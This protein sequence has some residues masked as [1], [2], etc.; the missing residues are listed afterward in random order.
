M[1]IAL[2][3]AALVSLAAVSLRK[4][5]RSEGGSSRSSF[6]S[7]VSYRQS[8]AKSNNENEEEEEEERGQWNSKADYLFTCIGYAVGLGNICRFPYLAY[9]NGGG[10]F[11]IPYVIMLILVGIPI[12]FMETSLGQYS[13]KGP[14]RVWS[15]CPLL[16]GI[17]IAQIVL[18]FYVGIY[19]NVIVSYAI[20]F[21][22]ASFDSAVPWATCTNWWNTERCIEPGATNGAVYQTQNVV[23]CQIN[24]KS[25]YDLFKGDAYGV[26]QL[27]VDNFGASTNQGWF[28]LDKDFDQLRDIDPDYATR[29]H[30]TCQSTLS[31][32]PAEEYMEQYVLGLAPE[33]SFL[34]DPVRWQNTLVFALAW[35]LVYMVLMNGIKEAG[36]IIWFTA[37]FPYVVLTIFLI[38][39]ATLGEF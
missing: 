8:K 24:Y 2:A 33:F 1:L 34:Q 25:L 19:Y 10:A 23:G 13:A 16:G 15:M 3:L 18:V 35:L 9:E 32:T 36:K 11:V 37:L 31:A 7:R 12:V 17:G 5:R 27:L 6:R 28:L 30:S 4:M 39:G 26:I 21:L 38:R 22:F 29:L 14:I 20:F